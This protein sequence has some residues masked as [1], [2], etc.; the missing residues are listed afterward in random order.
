M[1]PLGKGGEGGS[2]GLDDAGGGG[3][4]VVVVI[5]FAAFA[6]AAAF[7]L[8]PDAKEL[9]F[10]FSADAEGPEVAASRGVGF[11]G[12]GISARGAGL[13]FST[14]SLAGSKRTLS[15]AAVDALISE[16][17]TRAASTRAPGG[18]NPK[19]KPCLCLAQR[20]WRL[21]RILEAEA[22]GGRGAE[23]GA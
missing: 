13:G 6:A 19:S 3:G 12:G 8:E 9:P 16:A 7:A 14:V 18:N 5:V 22:G 1:A 17:G 23:G 4:G 10:S 2:S 11:D 21:L 15:L 20:E